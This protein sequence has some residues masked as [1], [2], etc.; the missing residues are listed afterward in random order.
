M[1]KTE[2]VK[3]GISLNNLIGYPGFMIFFSRRSTPL[4]HTRK[5]RVNSHDELISSDQTKNI[6]RWTIRIKIKNRPSVG[7]APVHFFILR[8]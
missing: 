5:L 2:V 3:P 8:V 4:D 7:L 6:A 1:S